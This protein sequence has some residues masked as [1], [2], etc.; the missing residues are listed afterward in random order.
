MAREERDEIAKWLIIIVLF[1]MAIA[2]L[3]AVIA[4][5]LAVINIGADLTTTWLRVVFQ[6]LIAIISVF[7]IF[8]SG[9]FI[10]TK[11][12]D[13]ICYIKVSH[14]KEIKQLKQ[15]GPTF[16]AGMCLLANSI[17]VIAGQS[18]PTDPIWTLVVSFLLLALFGVANNLVISPSDLWRFFGILLYILGFL[19]LPIVALWKHD[20]NLQDLCHWI[21]QLEFETQVMIGL[22]FLILFL[23]ILYLLK[24]ANSSDGTD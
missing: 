22:T 13:L 18:F 16:L 14:N 10:A 20:W 11:S 6:I 19:F 4:T 21:A 7:I 17:M 15:Y 1:I 12:L 23:S 3:L 24:F 8:F 9:C 5:L 2:T